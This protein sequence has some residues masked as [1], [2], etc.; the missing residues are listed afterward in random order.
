MVRAED[1]VLEASVGAGVTAQAAV[2]PV[3]SKDG[4]I[5]SIAVAVQ[6]LAPMEELERVRSEFPVVVSHKPRTCPGLSATFWTPAATR[7]APRRSP[8]NLSR[9]WGQWNRPGLVSE[10]RPPDTIEIDL[11][12][13]PPDRGRVVQV[14]LFE[15]GPSP[16]RQVPGVSSVDR[17]S[18]ATG[19][20]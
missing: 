11:P 19:P 5:E 8:G 12:C 13:V 10:R 18:R 9:W 15:R 4:A 20:R 3:R 2:A 1:I 14:P 7:R 17:H 6:D 16:A